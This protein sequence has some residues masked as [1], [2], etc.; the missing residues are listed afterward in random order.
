ML[1]SLQYASQHNK[2]SSLFKTNAK[3]YRSNTQDWKRTRVFSK[4]KEIHKVED[5][6]LLDLKQQ[7]KTRHYNVT[8]FHCV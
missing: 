2:I 7:T 6:R 8:P 1:Y 5:L 3:I 4:D